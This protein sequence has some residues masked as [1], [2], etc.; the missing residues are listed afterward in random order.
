M[1]R[2]AEILRVSHV[3]SK[4]NEQIKKGFG[5]VSLRGFLTFLEVLYLISENVI[6]QKK[7]KMNLR[8]WTYTFCVSGTKVT[9]RLFPK[10]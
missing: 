10:V 2:L 6:N 3:Y 5:R 8:N 9:L 7:V 1:H 4:E